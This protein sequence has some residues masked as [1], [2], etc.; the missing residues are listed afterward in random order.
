MKQITTLCDK[1][2]ELDGKRTQGEWSDLGEDCEIHAIEFTDGAGD[3][4]HISESITKKSDCD[5]II[6]TAN[7]AAKL[8]RALK[9]A[10][11]AMEHT[12]PNKFLEG[13][14]EFNRVKLKEIEEIF[15]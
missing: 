8:A 12:Y 10:I 1:I 13:V 4:F 2:I 14:N 7:H 3:P 9:V 6:H 5:F 11:D 15:K